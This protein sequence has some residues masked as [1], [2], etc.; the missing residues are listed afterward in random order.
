[1][2]SFY[3]EV[4]RYLNDDYQGGLTEFTLAGIGL[5]FDVLLIV[6]I[7]LI[8]LTTLQEVCN[9]VL[10]EHWYFITSNST[11]SIFFFLCTCVVSYNLTKL[12]LEKI[13]VVIAFKVNIIKQF[14]KIF[15]R[16][17]HCGQAVTKV[18]IFLIFYAR[19]SVWTY[20]DLVLFLN[21]DYVLLKFISKCDIIFSN[22]KMQKI[23]WF[24]SIIMRYVCIN[25][26]FKY[27]LAL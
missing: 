11:L 13:V 9:L 1:M 3:F 25:Y 23:I 21:C 26:F 18:Q 20:T 19:N 8:C 14:P 4:F 16:F 12:T 17:V 27:L 5:K 22:V 10:V 6:I 24:T 2:N 15:R 7:C